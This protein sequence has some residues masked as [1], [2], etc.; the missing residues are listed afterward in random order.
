[1]ERG[2]TRF[3]LHPCQLLT[4]ALVHSVA[5]RQVWGVLPAQVQRIWVREVLRVTVGGR[6]R[7]H[8]RLTGPDALTVD[9]DVLRG[10]SDQ[11]ELRDGQVAQQL[12]DGPVDHRGV[13][14]QGR[15]LRRVLQQGQGAQGQHVRGRLVA[16]NK[17]QVPDADQLLVGEGALGILSGDQAAEQVVARL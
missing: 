5:E 11:A 8:D 3:H 13:R 14:A 1:Q 10:N 17:Q 6:Q 12:L 16:G 2:E 7:G 15:Q 4:Q 9:L